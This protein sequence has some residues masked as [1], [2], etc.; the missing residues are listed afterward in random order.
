MTSAIDLTSAALARS[1]TNRPELSDPGAAELI[2]V[3][4]RLLREAFALA[5]T[6]NPLFYGTSLVVPY[7]VGPAASSSGWARPADAHA[8]VKLEASTDTRAVGDT[9]IAVGTEVLVVPFNDR[10]LESGTPAVYELGQLFVCAGNVGDPNVGGLVIFYQKRPATLTN[11]GDSLDALWQDEFNE[12]L[13]LGLAVY[14]AKKDQR[15]E[16][17]AAFD[18]ERQEWLAL[19][20]QSLRDASISTRQRY[21]QFRPVPREAGRAEDTTE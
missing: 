12:L 4:S 17:A 6:I 18:A 10:A 15:S 21:G 16:D 11:G 2:G 13:I 14:L 7:T 8:V 5:S 20:A 3:L 9:P 19:Y 1:Y